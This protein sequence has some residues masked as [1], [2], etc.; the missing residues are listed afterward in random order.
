MVNTFAGVLADGGAAPNTLL[1]TKSGPGTLILTNANT[2]TGVINID[3]GM[4]MA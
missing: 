2:A 3:G 1:L 4:V